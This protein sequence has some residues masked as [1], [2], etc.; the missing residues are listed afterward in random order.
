MTPNK[1]AW[2]GLVLRFSTGINLSL[3]FIE[4]ACVWKRLKSL[5]DP[6]TLTA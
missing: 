5:V 4:F 1:L 3:A 2:A 6:C